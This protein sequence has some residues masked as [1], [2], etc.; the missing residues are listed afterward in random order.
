MSVGALYSEQ[1]TLRKKSPCVSN[2]F[3]DMTILIHNLVIL[4]FAI[5]VISW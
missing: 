5:G 2:E 3:S 4:W 1:A